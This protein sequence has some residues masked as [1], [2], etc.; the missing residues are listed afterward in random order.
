MCGSVGPTKPQ[1]AVQL[2]DQ[3]EQFQEFLGIWEQAYG[4]GVLPNV[5]LGRFLCQD[6]SVL[7]KAARRRWGESLITEGSPGLFSASGAAPAS[8]ATQ[9]V[10]LRVKDN[11]YGLTVAQPRD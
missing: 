2:V 4:T 5:V 7:E 6:F 9:N 11:T 1:F 8:T 3:R 10:T